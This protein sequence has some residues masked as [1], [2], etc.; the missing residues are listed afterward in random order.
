MALPLKVTEQK[1]HPAPQKMTQLRLRGTFAGVRTQ[2]SA[3][4]TYKKHKKKL[5]IFKYRSSKDVTELYVYNPRD[6]NFLKS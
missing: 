4:A 5:G 2:A 1:T 3:D 6:D